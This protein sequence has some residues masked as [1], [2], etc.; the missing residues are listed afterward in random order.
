[1]HWVALLNDPTIYRLPPYTLVHLGGNQVC[2][3]CERTTNNLIL[4]TR[5]IRILESLGKKG[6][7]RHLFQRGLSGAIAS[8]GR[9]IRLLDLLTR[10]R[11]L[12]RVRFHCFKAA[13]ERLQPSN[14]PDRD[15]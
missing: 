3:I 1:M 14:T 10:S 15:S 2:L 4:S 12:T 6:S 13:A 11:V 7:F 5:D 8:P 9:V